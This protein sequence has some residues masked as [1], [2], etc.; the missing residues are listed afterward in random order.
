MISR[1]AQNGVITIAREESSNIDMRAYI[2]LSL[3]LLSSRGGDEEWAGQAKLLLERGGASA[4][5]QFQAPQAT[6]APHLI[7]P[8]PR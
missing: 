3:L 1:V 2:Y 6:S 7:N 8:A 4:H 5:G